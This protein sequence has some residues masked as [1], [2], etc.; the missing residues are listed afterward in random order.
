MSDEPTFLLCASD[1]LAPMLVR[2]WARHAANTGVDESKW[3]AA[4]ALADR[5][6]V[7]QGQHTQH[8]PPVPPETAHAANTKT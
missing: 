6:D 3:R 5:M 7:W 1:P 2:T 4:L 8:M